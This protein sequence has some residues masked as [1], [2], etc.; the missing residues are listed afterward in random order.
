MEN[1]EPLYDLDDSWDEDGEDE[2]V[3]PGTTPL[4]MATNWQVS[5]APPVC[6][7]LLRELQ[8]QGRQSRWPSSVF[9]PQS[10]CLLF[11]KKVCLSR[12]VFI[13][14]SLSVQDLGQQSS[15]CKSIW[16][17]RSELDERNTKFT[18]QVTHSELTPQS[19]PSQFLKPG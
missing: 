18:L 8:V 4:D 9:T 7:L 17:I 3:L 5:A 1:F 13:L 10:T 19:F 16:L 12:A 2:G 15:E 14:K 11:F 6:W